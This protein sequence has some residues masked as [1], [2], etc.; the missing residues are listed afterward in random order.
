MPRPSRPRPEVPPT[1]ASVIPLTPLRRVT[2]YH[3]EGCH[4][5][6]RA[7]EIVR[8]AQGLVPFT[9]ELIDIGGIEPLEAV[10]RELLPVIEIDGVREFSYFVTVDGLLDRLRRDGSSARRENEA[11]NM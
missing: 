5:C 9:L 3:A 1:D 11:G 8:D 7:I 10:Y 6:E 2:L 4:L